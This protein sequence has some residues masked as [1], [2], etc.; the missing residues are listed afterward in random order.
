MKKQY[1]VTKATPAG[2]AWV[3]SHG[4]T[5]QTFF[6][7]LEGVKDK[8]ATVNRKAES[9][10]LSGP[11]WFDV[12]EVT[13]KAGKAGLKLTVTQPDEAQTTIPLNGTPETP[14]PAIRWG[15]A[16]MAAA[17]QVKE[18]GVPAVLSFAKSLYC[19]DAPDLELEAKAAQAEKDAFKSHVDPN[20][21]DTVIDGLP[22]GP[23][24]V[25]MLPF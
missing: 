10:V 2:E 3:S 17:M 18:G 16:V 7:N 6:L 25:D 13:S 21:G 20:S 1:N 23:V 14:S 4:Q 9:P 22:D 11:T 8:W 24:Q 19:A 5:M 15:E 12:E